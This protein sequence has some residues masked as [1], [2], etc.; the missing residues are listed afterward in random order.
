MA[1]DQLCEP[2][3]VTVPQFLQIILQKYWSELG[4]VFRGQ[5]NIEWPLRPKAGRDEF[6]LKATSAWVEKGQSSSDLGRFNHWREQG[7]LIPTRYRKMI[8]SV[9]RLPSTTGLLRDCWIG[10]QTLSWRSS[11]LLKCK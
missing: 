8:L 2:K 1:E 3:F 11:L 5:D 9:S 6:Y 7:L 10:Q 4:W